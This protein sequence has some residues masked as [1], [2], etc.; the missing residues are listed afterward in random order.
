MLHVG[1]HVNV[2]LFH[3][4]T[5]KSPKSL[6]HDRWSALYNMGACSE[7][8]EI[9]PGSPAAFCHFLMD[10]SIRKSAG[11]PIVHPQAVQ[12]C[13][14]SEGVRRGLKDMQETGTLASSE[15][16]LCCFLQVF[17]RVA[18]SASLSSHSH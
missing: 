2:I 8:A 13:V 11:R 18:V 17:S 7:L 3:V 9:I 15:F 5:L 12:P 6:L 14:Q 10:A 1:L 16:P 4:F